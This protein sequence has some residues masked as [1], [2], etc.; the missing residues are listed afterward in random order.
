MRK[1]M[2]LAIIT[3]I[4]GSSVGFVIIN[5]FSS[6][7]ESFVITTLKPSDDSASSESYSNLANPD[8]EIFNYK[9]INPT[10]EVYVGDGSSTVITPTTNEN[11]NTPSDPQNEEQ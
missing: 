3:A 4:I 2:L 11:N 8:S 5:I 1:E 6:S 10:V 7:T 9:S